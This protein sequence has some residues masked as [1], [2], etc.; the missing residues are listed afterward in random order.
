MG[1]AALPFVSGGGL[2]VRAAT[3]ADDAVDIIRAANRLENVSDAVRVAGRAED[4]VDVARAGKR[5]EEIEGLSHFCSFSADTLV[6]TA[7]GERAIGTLRQGDHVLAYNEALDATGVYTV[8]VIWVHVD[9]T[10]VHITIDGER[11]ETTPEHPFYTQAQGW[12][13]AGDL[14]VETKVRQ[15]D[16]DYGVVQAVVVV[17]QPQAMYNL[18]VDQAH[19]FFVGS[20]QWLVH[21]ACNVQANKAKG[22]AFRD[23][24]ADMFQK[25]G[26]NVETEVVK[27]TPFG[28]RRIDVEVSD[29]SGTVLGGIETKVGGSRYTASQRTKD[30]WLQMQGYIVDLMRKK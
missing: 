9:E 11:I 6:A 19:T 12:V 22:D 2:A 20:Q 13:P 27:K 18:T 3:H 25:A 17:H 28:V 15:A 26:Y 10:L 29:A 14:A 16:G 21:N 5:L 4:A 8:T 24:V 7:N 1:S 30:A 23:E